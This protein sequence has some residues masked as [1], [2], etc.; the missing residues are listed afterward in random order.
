MKIEIAL[1]L[2]DTLEALAKSKPDAICSAIEQAVKKSLSQEIKVT[3]N[4]AFEGEDFYGE[5]IN[6][7]NNH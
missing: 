4:I 3:A 5:P 1:T 6:E 7:T 2:P